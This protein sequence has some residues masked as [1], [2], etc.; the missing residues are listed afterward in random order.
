M[1]D[2][3]MNPMEGEMIT[4]FAAIDPRAWAEKEKFRGAYLVPPGKIEI[5]V[6]NGS[7]DELAEELWATSE[8]VVGDV[9]EW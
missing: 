4:L 6:G 3:K 9:P 1:L 8:R 5:P 7:N 2:G